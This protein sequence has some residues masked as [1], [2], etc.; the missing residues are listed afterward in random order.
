MRAQDYEADKIRRLGTEVQEVQAVTPV[1]A[2]NGLA[3]IHT[4]FRGR[5]KF[6]ADFVFLAPD[7]LALSHDVGVQRQVEFVRQY[8][9]V[10]CGQ[11]RAGC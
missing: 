11:T 6:N 3:E 2:L 10:V 8:V 1:L 7:N 4:I 9:H 5:K